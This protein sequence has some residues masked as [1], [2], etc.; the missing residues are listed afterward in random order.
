MKLLLIILSFTLLLSQE[1]TEIIERYYS[2]EKKVAVTYKGTGL[3][4]KLIER[5]TFGI[6]G[7][8]IKF[9][10]ILN[11]NSYLSQNPNL[12]NAQDLEDHLK[13]SWESYK[14]VEQESII[15]QYL[16]FKQDSL[17]IIVIN[18]DNEY[19]EDNM[20]IEYLNYRKISG[21]IDIEIEM[22]DKDSFKIT[23][24]RE[25]L[26]LF[27]LV[28]PEATIIQYY[29]RIDGIPD[30]IHNKVEESLIKQ[31]LSNYTQSILDK[32]NSD[33]GIELIF[34]P[35]LP[36]KFQK[37][38]KNIT[39]LIKNYKKYN[40]NLITY[41]EK[42]SDQ[43]L[44]PVQ[45]QVLKDDEV[46]I[47]KG[48]MGIKLFYDSQ[49]EIISINQESTVGLE[50][51]ISS[52]I[53]KLLKSTYIS[54][55]DKFIG[56]IENEESQ[57]VIE[58]IKELYQI[59][60]LNLDNPI[61]QMISL[62]IISDIKNNLDDNQIN[63]LK[64]Y[65]AKGGNI[66]FAQN[67]I[68][69]DIQ[70]Q[71]AVPI[72]SNIFDILDSYGFTIKENLVLD[73]NCNQVNVQQQMGTFRMAVPM[74]YPFLPVLK[75]FDDNEI[76]LSGID[77][78]EMIFAS[79]I[80][81]NEKNSIYFEPLLHTSNYSNSMSEPFNLNPDPEENPIFSNL[82]E[83]S[84]CIGARVKIN[85]K[86]IITLISV[87]NFISNDLMSSPN[88]LSFI[89]NT[90]HHMVGDDELILLKNKKIDLVN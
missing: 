84:K 47:I 27:D 44:K 5:Y 55:N 25:R 11:P 58:K 31:N 78:L 43:E 4:E 30:E 75:E 56:I 66:L 20:K 87:S 24:I 34:S 51:T 63:N 39:A 65:I 72:A 18:I 85:N 71:Q 52:K 26:E 41:I 49:K 19:I 28:I 1:R 69:V 22:I 61:P 64:D 23:A 83:P 21:D 67:R 10:D 60:N 88:N 17:I 62:I 50:Y 38:Q 36:L 80:E 13:G 40:S 12:L 32:L 3:D 45:I 82:N 57:N 2:G 54:T 15:K 68:S 77:S 59:N 9:E 76:T 8:I 7:K 70:T 42:T 29:S 81:S 35:N 74:D 53:K 48:Y 33:L 73:R 89:M 90:I 79:E 14:I 6:S 86:S 37:V 16:D 46:E